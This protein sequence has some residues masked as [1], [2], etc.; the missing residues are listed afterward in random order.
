M[1]ERRFDPTVREWRTFTEPP[2]LALES[3]P[4]CDEAAAESYQL[5]VFDDPAPALRIPAPRP[6]VISTEL[7]AV[8]PALGVSEIVAYSSDHDAGLAGLDAEHIARLVDVWADRYA[9]LGA[10]PEISY[11]HILENR[12]KAAG[13]PLGHPHGR[14]RG[15]TDLP[16]RVAR[17]FDVAADHLAA[18]GTCVFCEVVAYERGDAVRVVAEN[19]Y[20]LA[21]VPFA[22]RFPFEVHITAHRHATSV[23]DL[24]DP[25][26]L[27]LAEMIKIVTA[28]YDDLVAGPAAYSMSMH[29][30]PTDDRAW[31]PLSHLRLEFV[32][33][34]SGEGG[35]TTLGAC[36]LGAGAFINRSKPEE[37]AAQLRAA[38]ARVR[39]TA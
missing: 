3:C 26:R 16:P 17:E 31:L 15:W 34:Y 35:I 38:V 37:S 36:E 32:A 28:A 11:V 20:F 30:A 33:P 19:P 25:E 21:F 7:Y 22:A 18:N 14:V 12:G 10:R 24:T 8:E 39:A 1:V 27:A 23:L 6:D 4:L 9:E 5:A 29:Q 13:E 2:A